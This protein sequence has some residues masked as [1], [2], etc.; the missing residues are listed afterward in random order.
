MKRGLRDEMNQPVLRPEHVAALRLGIAGLVLF[1]ISIHAIRKIRLT[2]WK[3]LAL[4]GVIGS[5]IPAV[6]FTISQQYLDSSVAGI[7]NA[8]TPL[9]TLIVGMAI[10]RRVVMP[11]QV[12]GVLIGLGGA[13][14]LIS[15]RGFGDSE[16]WT[17]SILIVIATFF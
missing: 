8:L 16:N 11:R 10:F 6:L 1:P 9:F 15:L 5:G 4:V 13:I 7:L 14:S 17:Y 12:M 3:W 2:D